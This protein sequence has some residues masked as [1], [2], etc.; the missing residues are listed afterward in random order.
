MMLKYVT[1]SSLV[2]AIAVTPKLVNATAY[3]TGVVFCH[4]HICQFTVYTKKHVKSRDQRLT[5]VKYFD[6]GANFPHDQFTH[7]FSRLDPHQIREGPT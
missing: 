1:F 7:A 3:N 4:G 2:L 6:P 5:L